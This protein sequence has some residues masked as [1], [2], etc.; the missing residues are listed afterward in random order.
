[1]THALNTVV[2]ASMNVEVWIHGLDTVVK[3]SINIEA[4]IQGHYNLN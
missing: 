1:M 2:K 3:S 4:W